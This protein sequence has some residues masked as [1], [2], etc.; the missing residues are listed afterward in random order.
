MKELFGVAIELSPGERA[1]FVAGA[2]PE[3]RGA[4]EE[5]IA[6]HDQADRFL[7][8]PAPPSERRVSW[9]GGDIG[10]YRLGALLGAGGMGEVYSAHDTQL[11]REVAIKV[12]Q[13]DEPDARAR[14]LREAR[15]AS[16]LNHPHICT[17]HHVGEEGG[18]PYIV[19]ER[20]FGRSLHD[21]IPR[22]GLPVGTALRHA[23][24]IASALAHAHARGVVHR[25][26]KTRNVMV[27]DAG[28]VKVLD[29]GLARRLQ[30][31]AQ[32]DESITLPGVIAG[33]PGFVPPEVLRGDPPDE[34]GDIFAMGVA[35]YEMLSGERPF[36]GESP[37]EINS[38]VL[39]DPPK[40]L[41]RQVPAV[42]STIVRRCLEKEP[43]HRYQT[44]AEVGAALEAAQ[45][46]IEAPDAVAPEAGRRR[47]GLRVHAAWAAAL[48]A[49]A[50]ALFWT[51]GR[52]SSPGVALPPNRVPVV[53]LMDSTLPGRIYDPRTAAAGSTNSDDITDALRD[54]PILLAKENTSALWHR[55]Q[56]VLQENPDLI[57][58]HLSCLLDERP[59]GDRPEVA[60][61]LFDL[62]TARLAQ[63][64]AYVASVN[65]RTQFLVYSRGAF[66]DPRYRNWQDDVVARFPALRGRLRL[67]SVPRQGSGFGPESSQAPASFRDPETGR[68][69]REQVKA[70]V[71]QAR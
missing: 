56:Q 24:E 52:T 27:T 39:R 3:S 12:M 11:D 8:P 2:D 66:E 18:R 67:F 54:L 36:R 17:V 38:A 28:Q 41:P 20:V 42:V 69:I 47:A 46:A 44:A 34:R 59:A 70:M 53:V 50:A 61:H 45:T 68:L 9:T 15:H 31:Q 64:F 57:V 71:E 6:S 48:V 37:A 7:Q 4:L 58:T 65:P 40:T 26:L 51:R 5:L 23:G 35:L 55:E 16:A 25:D 10:V 19:M 33:T 63:F 49:S 29:F 21:L 43:R 22:D 32:R 30:R 14:L 62:A 60:E 13:T 1:A